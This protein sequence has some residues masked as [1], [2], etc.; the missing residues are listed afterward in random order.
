MSIRVDY[1]D[2]KKTVKQYLLNL[3]LTE[4]QAET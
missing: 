4:E 1:E 3:G 2:V